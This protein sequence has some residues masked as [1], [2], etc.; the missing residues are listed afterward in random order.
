LV[1]AETVRSGGASA[2]KLIE[3]FASPENGMCA[4]ELI[5]VLVGMAVDRRLPFD[6]SR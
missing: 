2:I 5:S 3:L 1:V 4:E 6:T